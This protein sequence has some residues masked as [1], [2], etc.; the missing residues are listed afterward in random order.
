MKKSILIFALLALVSCVKET[1]TH[2]DGVLSKVTFTA[3]TAQTK[4]ALGEKDG[5]SWPINWSAGDAISVNGV[6]STALEASEAGS[7]Q[8]QFTVEGVTAPYFVA[9]PASAVKDYGN[10]VATVTIPEEQAYVAESFDPAAYLMLASANNEEIDFSPAVALFSITP[11]GEGSAKITSVRLSSQGGVP[12]SGE[13]S[14]DWNGLSP[15]SSSSAS[16]QICNADGVDLGTPWVFAIAAADLTADGIEVVVTDA[17]GGV[18]MRKATPSKAY[19]AGKLYTTEI[20][21]SPDF[22]GNIYGTVTCEGNPMEGVLVS[23]GIDIVETDANGR[24]AIQSEKKWEN[25]FV[26][27]P[28]GYEVP[29]DGVMPRHY[30]PLT[31]D[32][33]I[34]EQ[35]DFELTQ[36][37]SD[38]YRLL[39]LGDMHLARRTND[40]DQFAKVSK[41]IEEY[42]DSAPG[43]VYG[44][45]L[46]DLAW[47][48]YWVS[49]NFGLPEYVSTINAAFGSKEFPVFHTMGNHDNEMECSG[50]IDKAR[51]YI[52]TVAP[53]YYSFNLGQV[54]VIVLDDMDFTGVPEGQ[55]HRSEYHKN[56]TPDEIEWLRKDLSYVDPSQPII[57]TAHESLAVPDGLGWKEELNG[58]DIDKSTFLE[59]FS[60]YN[61]RMITGHTHSIFNRR[62]NDTF[63][64]H[65]YGA[66]CGTWWWSGYLTPGIHI[67]QEGSPGGFGVFEIDGTAI[68]HYYQAACQSRDYQFRAYDMNKV[69]EFLTEDYAGGHPDWTKYYNYIQNFDDNVIF[70]NVWD[71]DEDWNVEIFENGNPLTVTRVGGAYDPLHIAAFTGPRLKISSSSDSPSFQ[72]RKWNHFFKATASS[73]S[74][75]VT[76]RVTD[77]YGNVF[78][79]E[80]TRPK[81]FSIAEYRNE[82]QRTGLVASEY[83]QSSSTLTFKWTQG[84]SDGDDATSPY[85]AS[86]YRDQALTD[87]VV[88]F[89]I[90][91]GSS[92]WDGK[93]PRFVFGGLTPSTTYWFQVQ[94][95]DSGEKSDPISSTTEPFTVVDPSTVTNAGVG[96]VVLAEDFSEI[97]WGSDMLVSAAG[98]IPSGKPLEILSGN[99]TASDGNFQKYDNTAGRIYGEARV[100]SDKRLYNW[101]F[102]GNSAVFSYAGYLRVGSSDSGARTHIVSPAL[103]GI[104]EGKLATVDVTVTSARYDS[105]GGSDVAVFVNDHTA[106]TLVLAPD[107]KES[108]NP[109]FSSSGGKY[110]GASL[111]DGYPLDV[112]V[113]SW[114][115]KTVRIEGVT[116]NDC[117]LIGSYENIDKKNRFFLDDVK[118]Q[119]VSLEDMPKVSASLGKATSCTLSFTWTEGGTASEDVAKPWTIALYK[120]AA[121]TDLLVSHCIPAGHSCW[122][123]KKPRFVFGGLDAGTDY[124]FKAIDTTEGDV[125]YSNVVKATT[126]PFTRI[127]A[128]T[129]SNAAVGDII[130]AEDFS[131]VHYGP[132]EFDGAAGFMPDPRTLEPIVGEDPDGSFEIYNSTSTRL[133]GNKFTITEGTRLSHG[134]G[135]YGNSAVYS[136]TGYFRCATTQLNDNDGTGA[137]THIVTPKLAGI[138]EG[139]QATI[140]VTVTDRMYE[141]NGDVGVFVSS[142]LTMNTTTSTTS[143]SFCK[144]TGSG[145]LDTGYALGIGTGSWQ[146]KSVTISGVTNQD[147]LLIGS[148][149]DVVVSN[150]SKNRHNFS[151]IVV[152]IVALNDPHRTTKVSIIG[153]SISTFAGWCDTTKGG[154]YYPRSECDV[155]SVSDTW[156]HKVIYNKMTTGVYEAN[157]SAGNTTVVQNTTGD[158]G[159]YWYGWDFGTRLQQ[160]GIGNPDVVFIYGGTND[161]GHTLYNSTTEELIDGVE[162]GA[163]SFPD[164]SQDRLEELYADAEAATTASAADALD[165]TTFCS[166]YIRLIQMIK[167]RFP[168]A[169]V[170]CVIGDY[171]RPGQG[172]AISRIATLFGSDNVRVVDIL[173]KY[174]YKANS[175]IPKFDYAH[176]TAAG[177]S[178]IAN[179]VY[180]EVGDWIDVE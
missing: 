171:L 157:I 111:T 116:R 167:A 92:C 164:S 177:M 127:D 133:W 46:G 150:K 8:A 108:T 35:V 55:S 180:S 83:S 145:A 155:L 132:D 28:S 27:I 42:I 32:A 33:S 31:E 94:D 119:I 49:N 135:F 50:D 56:L 148:L 160:K 22:T 109:K 98:F 15:S 24:Y 104:P 156:W 53:T 41:S 99:Y 122:N 86:L 65:N 12:L 106:L 19:E 4:T 16:V 141:S 110:T 131:E 151:E 129:V 1:D 14:T 149:E 63:I 118:V 18:M 80:M 87:L 121:C 165:G 96:D 66:V 136:R 174:G 100:T 128:S 60:G 125:K 105:S 91:A 34:P 10:G 73:A 21:Y 5:N 126:L 48:M 47:D 76:V 139:Y 179:E 158:S 147:Q 11:I 57:V 17:D 29:K 75:T 25:V 7:P 95:T 130:L 102:F 54:H 153:D 9:S 124:W 71:W 77:R 161:Y 138:P 26:I 81:E 79:E 82:S 178:V 3:R 175:A 62:H 52:H 36:T 173:S 103:S 30:Q 67:G 44:I 134:W 154:A 37:G 38:T 162:M 113:K 13:F 101:G 45:T 6:A 176:P 140:E 90:P 159:A 117:L 170:V 2:Q 58:A 120:D 59:M 112:D 89:E 85:K 23:D 168:S 72:T 166:A 88:S 40:L 78:T 146:T 69:K 169:K 39:I 144:Y 123:N 114:T 84:D 74:S 43:K 107:Q 64:E 93:G 142:N 70:L 51:R 97:C 68:T 172:Q 143:P 115:T 61:V 152:K 20:P 137:R 163:S